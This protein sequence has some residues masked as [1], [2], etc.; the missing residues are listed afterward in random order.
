MR[1]CRLRQSHQ[2]PL[3]CV[4]EGEEEMINEFLIFIMISLDRNHSSVLIQRTGKA[5]N[6]VTT[7]INYVSL[8]LSTNGN[9]GGAFA[10]HR[11]YYRLA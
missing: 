10:C 8:E 9:V 5:S 3:Q 4:A 7:S 1:E 2:L 11:E 6:Q